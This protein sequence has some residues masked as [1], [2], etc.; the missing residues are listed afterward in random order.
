M[1]I[2]KIGRNRIRQYT[3][4]DIMIILQI[5][6]VTAL[7]LVNSGKLKSV[8]IGRQHW[9]NEDDLIAFLGDKKKKRSSDYRM[10]LIAKVKNPLVRFIVRLLM[11]S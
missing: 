2:L 10:E 7:N 6:K 9:I 5:S 1:R 8:R 4:N 3:V 11:R